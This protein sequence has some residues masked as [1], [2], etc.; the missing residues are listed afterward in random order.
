MASIVDAIAVGRFDVFAV[1]DGESRDD[2]A[3][4][5]E[6]HA[7]LGELMHFELGTRWRELF[8]D[9]ADLNI[10][11]HR[12]PEPVEDTFDPGRSP[13]I[14]RRAATTERI[15]Q[16]ARHPDV[17]QAVQMVMVKMSDEDLVDVTQSNTELPEALG[18]PAADI[19]QHTMLA[20]LDEGRRAETIET[21]DRVAGAE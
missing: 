4:F 12:L 6:Y 21:R 17:D 2:D 14:Q 9:D 7:V 10:R 3:V 18:R 1:I 15:R 16:P 20:G 5:V 8:V 13:D 19:E 11:I